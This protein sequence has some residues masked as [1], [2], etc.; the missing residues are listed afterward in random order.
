M[1]DDN[2]ASC[3]ETTPKTT[4]IDRPSARD[5]IVLAAVCLP[6]VCMSISLT[7]TAVVLP[8][9][10]RDFEGSAFALNWA[11]NAFMLA[12]GST[13]MAAGAAAD[14]HGRK[15]IFLG[16]V[17]LYAL[18]S[19]LLMAAPSLLAFDILRALQGLAAAASL[20]GGLAVLAQRFS[21]RFR[22]RAF[23]LVGVS[24]GLGIALGPV[25][26]GLLAGSFGWRS[27]FALT[28]VLTGTAA[29]L[30]A[31]VVQNSRDPGARG[32]DWA[33]SICFT[34]ML[35]LF[36]VGLLLMPDR[37]WDA[38][39]VSALIG[40]A[41]LMAA[42]VWIET[43]S[44]RPMLDLSL[45]RLPR[46]VGVQLLAMAP[47]Y[48]FVV[49]LVLLPIRFVGIDGMDPAH[50][51]IMMLFI[52]LPLL[53]LPVLAGYTARW[54]SVGTICAV[55]LTVTAAGIV[56]IGHLAVGLP[57]SAYIA[58]LLVIGAGISLPWG[59]MDGLAVSVVPNE[60]AGMA[61]GV[62]S[63]MRVAGESVALAVVSALFP[64]LISIRLAESPTAATRDAAQRLATGDLAEAL[65][66][67]PHAVQA[68]LVSTYS[69]A[70]GLLLNV[71]AAISLLIA[72]IVFAFL[73]KQSATAPQ[74]ASDAAAEKVA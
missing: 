28:L 49:L 42:F 51:G 5:W 68:E 62:F 70:F 38:I 7:G 18:T 21:G 8:L 57:S 58:P 29:I 63:T 20:S 27:V 35:S 64:A 9:I 12:F 55:G 22:M 25:A 34:A 3:S 13:L 73:R 15:T 66:L 31:V 4:V 41:V 30:A 36:T 65:R 14:A 47:A 60:R 23:S 39:V 40:A 71:L 45:F 46:F 69:H 32:I 26:A 10:G 48:S 54:I 43:R 50:A 11:T 17:L 74:V 67:L 16:G 24:F 44:S 2:N 52:A 59:L 37:G 6:G 33:G 56:W 53:V 19:A 1:A 72:A 61:A